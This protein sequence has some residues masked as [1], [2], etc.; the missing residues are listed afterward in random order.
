MQ[1]NELP[2][3]VYFDTLYLYIDVCMEGGN[4]VLRRFQQLR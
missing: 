4:S 1:R 3:V 2:I